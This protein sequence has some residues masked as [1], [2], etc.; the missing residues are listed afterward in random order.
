[1]LLPEIMKSVRLDKDKDKDNDKDND[2]DKEIMKSV[3]YVLIV[4][5]ILDIGDMAG[6][7]IVIGVNAIIIIIIIVFKITI[8]TLFL[9]TR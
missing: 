8:T 7:I 2:K 3:R 4:R 5:Y 1:M 6:K 9:L